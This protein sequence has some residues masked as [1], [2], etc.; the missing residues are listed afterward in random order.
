M[1][2]IAFIIENEAFKLDWVIVKHKI[3]IAHRHLMFL[4]TNYIFSKIWSI[5][6]I[7]WKY[8]KN[9]DNG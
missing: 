3:R 8:Y 1:N 6:I 2:F 4:I 7:P 9:P 5:D